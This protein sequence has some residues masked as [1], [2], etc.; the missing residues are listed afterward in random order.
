MLARP[1]TKP[2]AIESTWSADNF[3]PAIFRA[4]RQHYPEGENFAMAQDVERGFSRNYRDLSVRFVGLI[5]FI[6]SVLE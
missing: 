4:F 6:S 1:Q 2:L 3:D 5:A